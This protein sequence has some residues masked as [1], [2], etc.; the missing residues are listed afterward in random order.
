MLKNKVRLFRKSYTHYGVF[1]IWKTNTF[2][3][4]I[5]LS[6]S[7]ARWLY[8]N[9]SKGKGPALYSIDIVVQT[10]HPYNISIEKQVLVLKKIANFS[11]TVKKKL[12]TLFIWIE[13]CLWYKFWIQYFIKT[14]V[15][16]LAVH[17]YRLF[18]KSL[19][20]LHRTPKSE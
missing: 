14:H 11:Q 9:L 12:E 19:N 18:G 8:Q 13:K 4:A 10:K 2:S 20:T 1:E 5:T 15:V 7:A 3:E 16:C 17:C 6:S